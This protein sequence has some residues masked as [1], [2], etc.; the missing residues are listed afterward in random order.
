MDW[1]AV[2]VTFAFG[3]AGVR[4]P[5]ETGDT[6]MTWS[7]SFVTVTDQLTAQSLP[8][9]CATREIAVP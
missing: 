7:G 4:V 9:P 5:D 6:L 3:L 8:L 1:L 2:I